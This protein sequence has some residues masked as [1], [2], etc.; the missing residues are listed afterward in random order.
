MTPVKKPTDKMIRQLD[1]Y[2]ITLLQ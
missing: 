1:V 2:I